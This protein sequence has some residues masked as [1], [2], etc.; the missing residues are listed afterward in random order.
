MKDD[1]FYVVY[2]EHDLAE[3]H[4]MNIEDECLYFYT[5]ADVA[6]SVLNKLKKRYYE[7]KPI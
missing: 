1:N 5:V 2:L 4:V 7:N 6:N 3:V